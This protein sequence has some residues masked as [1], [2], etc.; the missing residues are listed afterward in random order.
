MWK[1]LILC[2]LLVFPLTAQTD[3]VQL[4]R[5]PLGLTQCVDGVPVTTIDST[6]EPQVIKEIQVHEAVHR[7][8]L[9]N[10]CELT[11]LRIKASPEAELSAES[12]AYCA[13]MRYAITTYGSDPRIYWQQLTR[14]LFKYFDYKFK[15][16]EIVESLKLYCPPIPY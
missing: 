15:P 3:S 4:R 12:E 8:Q 1:V 11:L 2:C 16:I 14:V 5:I 9:K 13:Q 6:L 10:N 7:E